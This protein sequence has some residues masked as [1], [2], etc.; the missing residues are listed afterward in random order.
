[1]Q[2]KSRDESD[3]EQKSNKSRRNAP[4]C[5]DDSKS[6][7][8]DCYYDASDKKKRYCNG[9]CTSL[10]SK[11]SLCNIFTIKTTE[12]KP[13]PFFCQKHIDQTTNGGEKPVTIHR[14]VK[15]VLYTHNHRFLQIK[16]RNEVRQQEEKK[17]RRRR[18]LYEPVR[19]ESRY[20]VN[21]VGRNLAQVIN[22]KIFEQFL[23]VSSVDTL[24]RIFAT[25]K[26]FAALLVDGHVVTWGCP[27]HGGDSSGV[28][29][30]LKNVVSICALQ[31]M[32]VARTDE[33]HVVR[34]GATQAELKYGEGRNRFTGVQ[35]TAQP[36]N[37]KENRRYKT[38]RGDGDFC[39]GQRLEDNDTWD[40]WGW[41]VLGNSEYKLKEFIDYKDAGGC[42]LLQKGQDEKDTREISWGGSEKRYRAKDVTTVVRNGKLLEMD[43]G[44]VHGYTPIPSNV[45][46]D[47]VIVNFHQNSFAALVNNTI[48][49]WGDVSNTITT[50][51]QQ[52]TDQR[53]KTVTAAGTGF[54]AVNQK[55]EVVYLG[56]LDD[57]LFVPETIQKE[58]EL[59]EVHR[60]YSSRDGKAVAAVLANGGVVVWGD[61]D[62]GGQLDYKPLQ[63]RVLLFE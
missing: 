2:R 8:K 45:E 36:I 38:I 42:V 37:V 62:S 30:D 46:V 6:D 3:D 29:Q 52:I 17:E 32:F 1:M 16:V 13:D 44:Q 11:L 23:P 58:M 60:L 5:D 40:V 54:V 10:D 28:Q 7:C 49:V 15:S 57:R 39:V 27:E 53:I 63:P 4:E 50:T 48:M 34:W 19:N 43:P 24:P 56:N 18:F 33:G 22:D 41:D 9:I 21:L 12:E 47:E 35:V 59:R 14:Q 51:I 25:N 20:R 61:E 55:D 26:A 31:S